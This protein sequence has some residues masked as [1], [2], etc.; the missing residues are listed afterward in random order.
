MAKWLAAQEMVDN[1]QAATGARLVVFARFDPE[2]QE[3]RVEAWAAS[4][5]SV[6]QYGLAAVAQ[7]DP[8]FDPGRV[9]IKANVNRWAQRL[10]LEGLPVAAPFEEIAQGTVDA[11]IVHVASAVLGLVHGL[12]CPVIVGDSVAGSLGFYTP[13]VMTNTQRRTAEAFSRQVALT[14]ENEQ[15]LAAER[16]QRRIAHDLHQA[17]LG[18]AAPVP[19][20]SAGVTALLATIVEAAVAAAGGCDGWLTL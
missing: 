1:A 4:H 17:A 15:V 20:D 12:L 13:E 7:F 18:I 14:L 6:I 9:A 2:R 11:R 19:D 10:Y 3:A 8:H 5:A 16:R